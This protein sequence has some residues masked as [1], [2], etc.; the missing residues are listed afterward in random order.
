MFLFFVFLKDRQTNTER[1]RGR[2][3]EREGENFKL[4][5]HGGR[6]DLW[7]VAAEK[8]WPKYIVLKF[9]N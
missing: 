5:E 6:V 3:T 8:K 9:L 4:G 2:G 7:A 1:K